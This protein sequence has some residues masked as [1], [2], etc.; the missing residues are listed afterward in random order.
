M[1]ICMISNYFLSLMSVLTMGYLIFYKCGIKRGMTPFFSIGIILFFEFLFGCIQMLSTGTFLLYVFLI[2][3]SCYVFLKQR[4][5]FFSYLKSDSICFFISVSVLWIV[6]YITTNKYF[7]TW[8]EY[9]HWGPFAKAIK[10]SNVLH[11]YNISL[12]FVH[13]SYQE[14]EA[15]LYYFFPFFILSMRN[16]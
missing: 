14:G 6:F 16:I 7:I 13:P 12:D 3:Y 11:I 10:E 2:G 1:I 9:S 15:L 4:K 5:Y 8:D